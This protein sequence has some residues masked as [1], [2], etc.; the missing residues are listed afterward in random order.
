MLTIELPG[1]VE[2]RLGLLAL[3]TGRTIQFYAR[4]AILEYLDEVEDRFMAINRIGEEGCLDHSD[5]P[6]QS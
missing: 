2:N 3:S 4:E 6:D 1:D 5:D